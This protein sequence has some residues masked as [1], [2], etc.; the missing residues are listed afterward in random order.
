M[1]T[2][3]ALHNVEAK[4]K[5]EV[6]A[7][8][9]HGKALKAVNLDEPRAQVHLRHVGSEQEQRWYLDSGASNHMTGSKEAF[10]ELDDNMTDTVKFG[11]GSR[12]A[13]QGRGT[14]IFRCQ[15]GKH[16]VL[17]DVYYIS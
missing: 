8:E 17:T 9:G 16:R 2:F 11:D 15:N 5:G 6:M 10:F 4:E 13:I 7:V 1:T 12:A 14:I 3:C